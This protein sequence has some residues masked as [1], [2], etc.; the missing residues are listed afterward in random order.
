LDGAVVAEAADILAMGEVV[1]G[2][3]LE[4]IAYVML[5]HGMLISSLDFDCL[6]F[7]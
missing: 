5:M 6:E 4:I 1:D 3:G 7:R 2:G